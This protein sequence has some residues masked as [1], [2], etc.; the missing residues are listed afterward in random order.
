MGPH[1]R[2]RRATGLT[3]EEAAEL[4]CR[5][6]PKP[7][8]AACRPDDAIRRMVSRYGRASR[9]AAKFVVTTLADKEGPA[10][11]D[12]GPVVGAAISVLTVAIAVIAMPDRPVGRLGTQER[13]RDDQARQ[14]AWVIGSPKSEPHERE[15]VGSD[16]RI[17]WDDRSVRREHCA[18]GHSVEI[19]APAAYLRR[20]D[21]HVVAVHAILRRE[22]RA[23]GECPVLDRGVPVV[24]ELQAIRRRW[25][26]QICRRDDKRC[27][28]GSQRRGVRPAVSSHRSCAV[29]G[30]VRA[31]K[32]AA[33]ATMRSRARSVR[34]S[35]SPSAVGAPVSR[36]RRWAD[37]RKVPTSRIG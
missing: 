32:L 16:D 15:E 12:P 4:G 8:R 30:P 24:R 5:R 9:P 3:P 22:G 36:S 25:L 19:G 34:R 18:I 35:L 27:D 23:R 7:A 10:S 6:C 17:A 1:E 11:A 28:D 33:P 37:L 31:R 13:I 29:A 14:D 26:R 2:H 21:P 20:R